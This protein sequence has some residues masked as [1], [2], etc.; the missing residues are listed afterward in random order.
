[1]KCIECGGETQ[2]RLVELLQPWG[3]KWYLF[4]DVPAHVC[5]QCGEQYFDADVMR[6]IDE[7]REDA[8]SSDEHITIPAVKFTEGNKAA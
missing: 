4:R 3:D 7:M 5:E 2:D 1:M 8:D 6:R